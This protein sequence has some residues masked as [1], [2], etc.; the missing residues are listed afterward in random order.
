LYRRP[1]CPLDADHDGHPGRPNSDAYADAERDGCQY[2]DGDAD[3]E[4]HRHIDAKFHPDHSANAH[5]DQ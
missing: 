1:V 5:A 4:L 2:G 3:P